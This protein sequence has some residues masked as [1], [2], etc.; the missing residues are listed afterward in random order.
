MNPAKIA[1]LA[2]TA[3]IFLAPLS[4]SFSLSTDPEATKYR[5]HGAEIDGLSNLDDNSTIKIWIEDSNEM[6]LQNLYFY[7]HEETGEPVYYKTEGKHIDSGTIV[8][9]WDIDGKYQ[10]DRNYTIKA[11][12][13]MNG[14]HETVE[15]EFS[16]ERVRDPDYIGDFFISLA[17]N[18][19]VIAV[20]ITLILVLFIIALI[21]RYS[22]GYI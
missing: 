12:G 3:A 21:W 1:I 19:W 22:V 16:V 9:N 13:P 4:T 7:T 15:A 14:E 11:V 5:T 6:P 18:P 2:T 8:L 17:R 10:K 20:V